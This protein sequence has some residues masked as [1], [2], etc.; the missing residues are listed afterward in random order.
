MLIL[1]FDLHIQILKSENGLLACSNDLVWTSGFCLPLYSRSPKG[2]SGASCQ[3]RLLGTNREPHGPMCLMVLFKVGSPKFC[4]SMGHEGY[5]GT[6]GY[7]G[8]FE[9]RRRGEC[10]NCIYHS[11]AISNVQNILLCSYSTFELTWAKLISNVYICYFIG[12]AP[13]T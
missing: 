12:D 10:N 3:T 2:K 4:F 7:T 8:C 5:T 13:A 1:G 11:F 6:F 9:R